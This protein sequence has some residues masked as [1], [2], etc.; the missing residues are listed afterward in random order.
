MIKKALIA[1]SGGVDS[2]VAAFLMK[3]QGYD[4]SAVTLQLFEKA[5]GDVQGTQGTQGTQ[6][7]QDARSVASRL[8]M[9]FHVLDFTEKFGEKVV[10]PF[11]ESYIRG[12]TPNPCIDCNR[13]V[14][15]EHL[16]GQEIMQD[17]DY[18]V[19]GHYA[20]IEYDCNKGRYLLKKAAD[21][22]KDQSYVLYTLTQ[23]QLAHVL[24]PLGGL[25][26]A[27]VRKIAEEE[28]FTNAKRKDSQ[29][30]C[31]I[32]DGDYAGFIEKQKGIAFEEGDFLNTEG[33]TLGKHKGIIHY[34][35]GQRK[36]LGLSMGRAV[37]VCDKSSD[38]NTVTVGEETELFKSSLTAKNINLILWDKLDSPTRLS[39]RIRYQQKEQL[40]TVT[41][42]DEDTLRIEFDSPQRAISKGQAVV[43]Y[44]GEYVAG[45]G[46]IQ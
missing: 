40:A 38:L 21:L 22:S 9:P 20:G 13:Y 3:Q 5:E 23:A 46:T 4:C 12:E 14:K 31:F 17:K 1:M 10:S 29:D 24:F 45:G 33:E 39:A 7:V 2:S 18:V 44:D 19:T 41:Q 36:G 43:L 28:G 8:D 26:K 35:I 16:L 15:F 42:V 30:I 11:I 6:G 32:P 25:T 34:T 27:E 37:Y